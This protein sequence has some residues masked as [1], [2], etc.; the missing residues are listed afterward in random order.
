MC[1]IILLVSSHFSQVGYSIDLVGGLN[2]EHLLTAIV[3]VVVSA[4]LL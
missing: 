2:P 3:N 1:I 4:K